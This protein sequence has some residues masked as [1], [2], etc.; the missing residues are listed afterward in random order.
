MFRR[1]RRKSDKIR[2]EHAFSGILL[3]AAAM[4]DFLDDL[5]WI[6]LALVVVFGGLGVGAGWLIWGA[7]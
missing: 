7:P 4:D 2:P 5:P 3:L 1:K 6:I